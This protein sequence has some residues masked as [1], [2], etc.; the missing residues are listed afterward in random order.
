MKGLDSPTKSDAI[1][2]LHNALELAERSFAGISDLFVKEV[3]H[4]LLPSYDSHMLQE[5]LEK[6][7]RYVMKFITKF[8]I[9]LVF[10]EFLSEYI[11]LS[12]SIYK[13]KNTYKYISYTIANFY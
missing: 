1:E 11:N 12:V 9:M 6:L 3:F 5:I 13:T 10:I 8:K 2:E 7:S 4:R